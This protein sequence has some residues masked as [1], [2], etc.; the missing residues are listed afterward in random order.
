MCGIKVFHLAFEPTGSAACAVND[1]G[2]AILL[3][4]NQIRWRRNFDL[5]HEL[6]HILTWHIFR[7]D[8]D[9]DVV[10]NEKEE[11]FATCFASNLLMPRY[12]VRHAI[13]QVIDDNKISFAD[14][15]NIARQFDVSVEALCW[16][17]GFLK[18]FDLEQIPNIAERYRIHSAKWESGRE[19]DNPPTRPPRF[20][21][22]AKKALRQGYIS[23]GRFAEY[24]EISRREAWQYVEQETEENETIEISPA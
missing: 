19:H 10:N 7:T 9:D 24:M 2:A 20:E 4:A 6:F 16:R 1:A 18:Y 3:N 8:Q 5:A 23:L 22:L 15:F 17:M 14:M 13:N 11:K 21:A 12:A